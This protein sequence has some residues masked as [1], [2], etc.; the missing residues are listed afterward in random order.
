MKAEEIEQRI[1]DEYRK[2]PRLVWSKIASIK[3]AKEYADLA[4]KDAIGFFNW[5]ANL[6]HGN[7]AERDW[8]T[9]KITTEEFYQIY[10]ADE[11]T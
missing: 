11:S 6:P 3:I 2:H 10:K 8:L 7:Q 1:K 4:K 5:S 9:G